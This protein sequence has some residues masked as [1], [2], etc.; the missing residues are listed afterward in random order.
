M[1]LA[2]GVARGD[3]V[4]AILPP[5]SDGSSVLLFAGGTL[6][7]GKTSD[8]ADVVTI[9]TQRGCQSVAIK[10]AGK[11]KQARAR[12]V[13]IT[14]SGGDVLVAGGSQITAGTVVSASAGEVF[15]APR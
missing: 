8:A 11:L 5:L 4:S 1:S 12:A 7:S 6:S 15:I 14:L 2:L 10:P 3:L 13:A 9:G